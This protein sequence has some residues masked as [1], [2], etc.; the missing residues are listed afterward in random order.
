MPSEKYI[1]YKMKIF[2]VNVTIV[3]TLFGAKLHG[4]FQGVLPKD[5]ATRGFMLIFLQH[6]IEQFQCD[7]RLCPYLSIY[8][9]REISI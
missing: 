9:Y 6:K 1:K 8:L 5:M 7:R 2:E 4:R 3:I